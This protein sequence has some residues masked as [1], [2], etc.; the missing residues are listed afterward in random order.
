[1]HD[2]G[3]LCDQVDPVGAEIARTVVELLTRLKA[4]ALPRRA[5]NGGSIDWLR[6]YTLC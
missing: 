3:L 1:M 5:D 4:G 2:G 6:E